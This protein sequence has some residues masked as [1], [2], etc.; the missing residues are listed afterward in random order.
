SAQALHVLEEARRRKRWSGELSLRRADGT[1]VQASARAEAAGRSVVWSITPPGAVGG[2]ELASHVRQALHDFPLPAQALDLDGRVIATNRAWVDLFGQG[3]PPSGEPPNALR[4]G[5]VFGPQ[6]R[7]ALQD[8][9]RGQ[10]VRLQNF[11]WPP[12]DARRPGPPSRILE[13]LL[14]PIHDPQGH[15]QFVLA[16]ALDITEQR[17]LE[18][19]LRESEARYRTLI[20]ESPDGVFLLEDGL[21]RFV[22]RRFLQIFR[23]TSAECVDR[24]G[25]LA[26]CAPEDRP[27]LANYLRE[28]LASPSPGEAVGFVGLRPDGSRL[29]CELQANRVVLRGKPMLLGTVRDLTEHRRVAEM[30][31]FQASLLEQVQDAIVATDW[32]GRVVYWNRAAEAL[33]GWLASDALG[34]DFD[35]LVQPEARDSLARL[36]QHLLRDGTW[37]GELRHRTADGQVSWLSASLSV[38]RDAQGRPVGVLGVY[39]DITAN[40]RLEEEL[41]Q[42]QK[43]ESIG[44]LAGGIAHDFNNILGT[45]VG[46]LGLL[47]EELPSTPELQRYF[48][49]LERSALRASEL[50]RQLLG[51]AR[52]GKFEVR[53]LDLARLCSEVTE[54]F[55][56]TLDPRIELRTRFPSDLPMVEGD[57][58]QLHQAVLNLCMNARDAMPE[59]GVLELVLQPVIAPDPTSGEPPVL[60]P[61]VCLTV[62]DTGVGMDEHVKARMFEPFFTTKGPG[63]GTGLGLAMVY[64]IVRNHGGF[65]E[66]DSEVGKGTAVRMYLP[67]ASGA[68]EPEEAGEAEVDGGAGETILVVDDEEPLCNLLRDVLTRRGYRVLVATDGQ[69]ALRLYQEHAGRIDLVI[70]DMTMPGLSGTQTFD[71]LRALDPRVRILLTSGYTQERAARDAVARGAKGFLQKPFLISELAARV[72]EALQDD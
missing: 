71:A 67:V 11:P 24:L 27:K 10:V 22:N 12:P 28:R 39:R 45:I 5:S 35:S 37:R 70:L 21:F 40:K 7:S 55:R 29:E 20:E 13:V 38:Q 49:V 1:V 34:R 15:L 57:A 56:S 69:E 2:R 62:R 54:L 32:D 33:Y 58:S 6:H 30:L 31:H 53:P 25:P 36:R 8:A 65:L 46:Y 66:V 68:A 48:D 60:R 59:G 42:A 52:K 63:K 3:P 64:G 61:Y 51:F 18:E 17:R 14:A 19:E 23:T 4:G 72:R 41:L 26:L 9:L 44:T 16:T 47:K 43:M 50:T